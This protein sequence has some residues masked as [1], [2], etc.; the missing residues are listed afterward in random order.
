M[1][2]PPAKEFLIISLCLGL[3]C[4]HFHFKMN[5]CVPMFTIFVLFCFY[6][7]SYAQENEKCECDILQIST[8]GEI[9]NFT[10]QGEINERPF[11][12]SIKD[13]QEDIVWWN[14]TA[15]IWMLQYKNDTILL[16]ET[17]LKVEQ[18][19]KCPNF[20]NTT[21]WTVHL[22]G[23][24]GELKSRCLTDKYKCPGEFDNKSAV[25]FWRKCC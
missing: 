5:F 13:D 8:S 15:S 21:D 25:Y 11:Y 4:R 6:Q 3:G 12:F 18:D 14:H 7:N 19:I 24:N 22:D 9:T 17:L 10:K 20:S 23:N 16:W 2:F 1:R